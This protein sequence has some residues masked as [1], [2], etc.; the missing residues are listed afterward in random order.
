MKKNK[1]FPLII[2]SGSRNFLEMRM[3]SKRTTRLWMVPSKFILLSAVLLEEFKL[4]CWA[5]KISGSPSNLS[6]YI[7]SKTSLHIL[8]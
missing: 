3:Q 2:A 5:R 7:E 1:R 8:I 6:K 4:Y